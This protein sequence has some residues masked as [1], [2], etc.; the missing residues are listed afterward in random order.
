MQYLLRYASDL[1]VN[2]SKIGEWWGGHP[3]LKKEVQLDIVALASKENNVSSGNQYLIGSCKYTNEPV[4]TD[5]YKLIQEYASVFTNGN[6]TTYYCIFPK[7]GFTS[8]LKELS[9]HEPV[10][11]ITLEE[12]Y[13]AMH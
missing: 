5:E 6:D 13:E 1:S 11:L 10:K 4:G 2:I 7:S 12:M 8:A 9:A 3:V